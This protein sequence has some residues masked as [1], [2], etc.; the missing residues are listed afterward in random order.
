[1]RLFAIAYL[2]VDCQ[3][4]E[5]AHRYVDDVVLWASITSDMIKRHGAARTCV[6]ES[7]TLIGRDPPSR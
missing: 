6:L 5:W 1:M 7:R 4:T 2:A 3:P